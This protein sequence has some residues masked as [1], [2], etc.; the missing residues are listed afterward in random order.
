MKLS[1]RNA[2]RPELIYVSGLQPFASMPSRTW[3]FGSGWYT[4]RFQRSIALDLGWLGGH[5]LYVEDG[6]YRGDEALDVGRA[7]GDSGLG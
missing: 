1:V 5:R 2:V 7:C 6:Y 3:A 4:A